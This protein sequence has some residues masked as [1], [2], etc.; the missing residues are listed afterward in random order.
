MTDSRMA[1]RS[2]SLALA[3]RRTLMAGLA[4]VALVPL[5]GCGRKAPRSQA[6]PTGATVL[7]LGD[8]LTSGVG[9]SADTAYP[10]VLVRI[11][12]TVEAPIW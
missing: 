3:R 9:A 10:A 5:A 2:D 12:Q 7:A 6:V 8:S 4:A 1:L 11:F